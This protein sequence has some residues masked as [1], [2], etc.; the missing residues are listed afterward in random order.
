MSHLYFK[1]S[2]VQKDGTEHPMCHVSWSDFRCL[3]LNNRGYPIYWAIDPDG[4][5]HI[6][7]KTYGIEYE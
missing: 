6:Y 2:S 3:N 1:I 4:R 7:P 5:I